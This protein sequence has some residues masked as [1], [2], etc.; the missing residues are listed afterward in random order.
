MTVITRWNPAFRE[1]AT[2][3][4]RLNRLLHETAGGEET[5][6]TTSGAFVPPVDVYEDEQGLRL[7]LEVPGIDEKDLDVS[8]ENNTLTVRG[9]RKFEKE[10]KEENFR[11]VERRYGSFVRSFTLPTT[12]DA[13]K[14]TA[15]YKN[16]VLELALGKKAEAKPK[17]I[18]VNVGSEPSTEMKKSASA[19]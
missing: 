4:G 18:K 12:V 2:L 7:K 3:Q 11:R 1:L 19:A 14:V 17:Q 13:E 6:L 15:A 8:I 5:S 9:E 16:G 10:E